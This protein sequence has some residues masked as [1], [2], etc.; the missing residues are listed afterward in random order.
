MQSPIDISPLVPYEQYMGDN[1]LVFSPGY[2]QNLDDLTLINDGATREFKISC[3][4]FR[5][6]LP[7]N[8]NQPSNSPTSI[9]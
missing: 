7:T 1:P 3:T 6:R 2:N 4:S 5:Q 9:K 8:T